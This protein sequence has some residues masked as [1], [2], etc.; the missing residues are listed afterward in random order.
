MKR[1]KRSHQ[2]GITVLVVSIRSDASSLAKRRAS[3]VSAQGR[4]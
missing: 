3:V 2:A 1:G 4:Y